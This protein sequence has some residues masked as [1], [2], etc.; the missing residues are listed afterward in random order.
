M[1]DAAQRR[2]EAALGNDTGP[3][4]LIAALGC[5]ALVLFSRESDPALSRPRGP[6][7]ELIQLQYTEGPLGIAQSVNCS[8]GVIGL[9]LL[10]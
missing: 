10:G 7:I 1:T 5:P 4:H 9:S 8:V 6:A 3:M 2:A